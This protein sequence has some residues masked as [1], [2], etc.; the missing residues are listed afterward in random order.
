M[1]DAQIARHIKP[2]LDRIAQKLIQCGLRADFVTLI[3]FLLGLTSAGCIALGYFWVG[4]VVLLMSRLLDGLDGAMARQTVVTDRGGFL[5]ITFDFIFYASIPL[6]FAIQNPAEN[7]LAAA[8][9]L[10]TFMGTAASFLAFAAL[11]A[12]R[13]MPVDGKSI[14]FLGGLTESFETLLLFCLMCSFPNHFA[15]LAYLFAFLCSLTT[16]DRIRAAWNSLT[17]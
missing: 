13:Q 3:G 2:S 7:A 11:A 9:L 5:D 1:F 10:F 4:F 16:L 12:K 17:E 6:A 15:A 8:T 14:Y